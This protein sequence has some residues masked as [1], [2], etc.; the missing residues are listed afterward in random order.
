MEEVQFGDLVKGEV[1]YI[2]YNSSSNPDVDRTTKKWPS[3]INII[4]LILTAMM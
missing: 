2:E 1:Y 3:S 4:K